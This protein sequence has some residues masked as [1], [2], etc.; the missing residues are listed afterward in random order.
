[1]ASRRGGKTRYIFLTVFSVFFLHLAGL[2][3][4]C[5][6]VFPFFRDHRVSSDRLL[7]SSHILTGKILKRFKSGLTLTKKADINLVF[8]HLHS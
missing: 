6:F 5:L 2:E 8:F 7:D 4:N 3:S 1:M